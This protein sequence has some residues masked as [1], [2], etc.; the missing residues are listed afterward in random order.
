M[1]GFR[2]YPLPAYSHIP[3]RKCPICGKPIQNFEMHTRNREDH[4]IFRALQNKILYD[5][6]KEFAETHPN[7][8]IDSGIATVLNQRAWDLAIERLGGSSEP[9]KVEQKLPKYAITE[10]TICPKTGKKADKEFCKAHCLSCA[11]YG[12]PTQ[13]KY[14]VCMELRQ[15]R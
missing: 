11:I 2:G 13:P 14:Y 6:V 9:V 4:R 3:H 7:I 15:K 5:L 10:D 12:S 1:S 8:N